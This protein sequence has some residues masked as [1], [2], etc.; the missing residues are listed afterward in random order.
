MDFKVRCIVSQQSPITEDKIISIIS[1]EVA[2]Q[3]PRLIS[4]SLWYGQYIIWNPCNHTNVNRYSNTEDC[5]DTV[6]CAAEYVQ[7]KWN[8]ICVIYI[9]NVVCYVFSIVVC[10]THSACIHAVDLWKQYTLNPEDIKYIMMLTSTRVSVYPKTK[11]ENCVAFDP[12][13]RL[14][15]PW[16]DPKNVTFASMYSPHPLKVYALP[17]RVLMW[18]SPQPHA[19]QNKQP[20]KSLW[21]YW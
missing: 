21:S 19:A 6:L 1:I 11:A 2:Q 10:F 13:T 3:P 16:K 20:K 18:G 4:V 5:S 8:R 15:R 17:S 7:H 9:C 12:G 14:V